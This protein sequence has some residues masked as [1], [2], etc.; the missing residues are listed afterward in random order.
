MFYFIYINYLFI[1]GH[2][3]T[4]S[5]ISFAFYNIAKHPEVQQKVFDEIVSVF[6]N[7]LKK[8]ATIS[9]LNDLKYLDLVIKET[10]RLHPSVGLFG[11]KA[12]EEVEISKN[13]Y[14]NQISI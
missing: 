13:N 12:L 3:T 5:G 4:T 9:D 8:Q 6:G 7:D 10:L 1:Q 14:W 2:D 11:R